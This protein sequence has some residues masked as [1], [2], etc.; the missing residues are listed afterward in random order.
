MER[1]KKFL[2]DRV[3]QEI[4]AGLSPSKISKKHNISKQNLNYYVGK[5]KKLGLI[6]KKGYGVWVCTRNI[7]QVKTLTTRQYNKKT[8]TSSKKEIR[9][10][11]FIWKIHFD[12]PIYW[13]GYVNK[14]Q[15]KK[16]SFQL[17]KHNNIL[18]TVFQNRKI[19]LGKKG[20]IIYEPIDFMG[21]SSFEV[22]GKAVFEMDLLIKNLLKEL[23]IIFR[24]YKFTTSREHYGIMKN[25]LARQY[26]D[27]KEKMAIR[28]SD[29][30]VW[31]W[32]DDSKGLGELENKEP[33][34]NRQVQNFW[35]NHKKHGFNID[36]D[37][38]LGGFNENTQAINR[39]VAHIEKNAQHLEFYLENMKS[40][41][42]AIQQLG[43][44][45]ETLSKQVEDI[46]GKSE[47]L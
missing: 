23:G 25:E 32:I 20:M 27:R 37:F 10:H 33:N 14:Y 43:N 8:F 46:K 38:V 15:K 4:K 3:Y 26:N 19:W 18:R 12:D 13:E 11:A 21:R 1:G 47:H 29:G 9:G 30:D 42:K 39:N 24:P 44:A 40:H 16:L 5:L 31:M 6:E 36:A 35:N 17:M 7:K 2:L 22:K 45:V 28:S 34:V 41:V